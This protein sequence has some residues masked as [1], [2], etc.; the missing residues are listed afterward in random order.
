MVISPGLLGMFIAVKDHL[1]LPALWTEESN[2][3]VVER[4]SPARE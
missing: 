2:I 4:K 1:N 3:G